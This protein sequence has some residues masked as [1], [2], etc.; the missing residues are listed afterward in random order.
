MTLRMARMREGYNRRRHNHGIYR[1]GTQM[2][3]IAIAILIHA[4]LNYLSRLRVHLDIK[5]ANVCDECDGKG[6]WK[7]R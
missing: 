3:F 6:C 7:C 4:V 5:T 2:E 1:L